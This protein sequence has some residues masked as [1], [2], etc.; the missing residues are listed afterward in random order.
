MKRDIY[1]CSFADSKMKS[2]LQRIGKEAQNFKLFK[3][4]FLY[5]EN[6]LPSCTKERCEEIIKTTNSLRGYGYWIWKPLII[7]DSLSKIKDGDILFYSD[8]GSHLNCNGKSLFK[9]YIKNAIKKDIWVGQL[10]DNFNE[11]KYSK[12]DTIEW[13]KPRLKDTSILFQGQIQ[14]GNII[15]VKNSYTLDIIKIWNDIMDIKN[16]HLYDDSPSIIPNHKD[17]VEHR[18]DQSIFSLLIK[19]NHAYL[20]NAEEFWCPHELW[21]QCKMPILN[22]RDKSDKYGPIQFIKLHNRFI[23]WARR[24]YHSLIKNK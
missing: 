10:K 14:S 9:K 15:L 13:F 5:T 6:E 24:N 20:S 23:N 21:D 1:F 17:F 16:L 4:I 8:A 12:A 7:L 11:N 22:M 18:H 19:T 2:T 3:E